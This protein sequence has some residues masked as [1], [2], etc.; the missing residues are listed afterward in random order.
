MVDKNLCVPI[1]EEGLL[2]RKPEGSGDTSVNLKK[3]KDE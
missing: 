2:A 3:V 1:M